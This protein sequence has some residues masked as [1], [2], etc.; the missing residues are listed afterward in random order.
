MLYCY[1]IME[2]SGD[3]KISRR[4]VLKAIGIGL[5]SAKLGVAGESR[6]Q[7]ETEI[8]AA[9]EVPPSLMLHA[10]YSHEQLLPGLITELKNQGY[11]GVT[12][13]QILQNLNGEGTLP[14]KPVIIS[15]DDLSM[16][17]GV[18]AYETFARMADIFN[19]NNFPGVFA[20]NT[21]PDE[22]QD[23]SRWQ[24]V[25][26][27]TSRGIELA[28]HTALHTDL[29]RQDL[30]PG[31]FTAEIVEANQTIQE[32]T[33][34]QITTLILP[35]GKGYNNQT[36]QIRTEIADSCR[37]AGIQIAVGIVGGRNQLP[38]QNPDG[39]YL[40]GRTPPGAQDNESVDSA[41]WE[42]NHW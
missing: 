25:S 13:K 16:A 10:R 41:V 29:S 42:V 33:G 36:G 40:M 37:E 27:W 4:N 26:T 9:V 11:E 19:Q 7:S 39:I 22:I 14:E 12:Y 23:D 18:P 5:L 17:R 21:K 30:H 15:V 2:V 35:F 3:G 34:Q 32:R 1:L 24:E 6:A 31:D 38:T 8:P 28:N 20:I